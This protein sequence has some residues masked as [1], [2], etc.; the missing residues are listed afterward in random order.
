MKIK[1]TKIIET[2]PFPYDTLYLS[3]KKIGEGAQGTVYLT[4]DE[5]FA[6]KIFHDWSALESINI[7]IPLI[8]KLK[9][10]FKNSPND[11]FSH[12]CLQ[13]FPIC[14]FKFDSQNGEIYGM[15]SFYLKGWKDLLA[16]WN[17]VARLNNEMKYKLC[18]DIAKCFN[19][20]F[21]IGYVYID[22]SYSNI[23]VSPST[24]P[25]LALLDF[26]SG[27]LLT[28]LNSRPATIGKTEGFEAPEIFLKNATNKINAYTDWWALAI[29]FFIILTSGIYPFIFLK[30]LGQLVNYV[31]NAKWP[32]YDPKFWVNGNQ[33]LHNLFKE[34][35]RKMN[36]ELLKLFKKTFNEGLLEPHNRT[37]PYEWFSI[38]ESLLNGKKNTITVK[39]NQVNPLKPKFIHHKIE[40]KQIGRQ[41]YII[42]QWKTNNSKFVIVKFNNKFTAQKSP[43]DKI[44]LPHKNQQMEIKLIA[45]SSKDNFETLTLKI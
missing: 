6:V 11:I 22:I 15:V 39:P 43:N 37:S 26:E 3:D 34:S 44:M 4:N 12:P 32:N 7:L 8:E 35:I 2:I 21:S 28:Q 41:N 17:L 14:V 5:R 25:Q 29:L 40:T 30:D 9:N 38:F 45:F 27:G 33:R 19:M 42:I 24:T 10:N 36:P 1:I 23:L 20:F 18:R 16:S 13:A 31:N